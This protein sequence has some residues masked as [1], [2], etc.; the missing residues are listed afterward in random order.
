MG[1]P[2]L[3]QRNGARSL[4]V[5]RELRARARQQAAV[6]ALGQRAL[7]GLG[8]TELLDEAVRVVANTLGVEY[9]KYLEVAPERPHSLF[10]RSGFGWRDGLVGKEYVDRTKGSQ[11]L[12]TLQAAEPVIVEDLR[13]EKR[14][15]SPK[16][17]RDHGVVSG[18]SVLV[19]GP[20]GPYGVLGAHSSRK[21]IFS[22]DDV[23]FLQSVANVLAAAIERRRVE[24]DLSYERECYR[25]LFET[26]LD[27][28]ILTD[29]DGS[30]VDANL[31]AC[32]LTG[33]SREDLLEMTFFD[34][35]PENERDS[36]RDNYRRFTKIGTHQGE[37]GLVRKDGNTVEV[38]YSAA[39]VQRGLFQLVMRDVT[40]RNNLQRMREAFM[41]LA[42]HELR[43]P[44]TTLKGY[45]QILIS[46]SANDPEKARMYH[47]INH[48]SDRLSH[49]VQTLLDLSQIQAG[50]LSL[51]RKRLDLR[52]IVR[53]VA[54]E[55]EDER[56]R[57]IELSLPDEA[58]VVDADPRRVREV[59]FH[60]LD[61]AVKYSPAADKVDVAIECRDGQATVS[62]RDYG[63]GIPPLKQDQLFQ[64]FFQ[65]APMTNPTTGMGLGLHISRVIVHGHGG[66]IWF[67]SE[68]GVG[69]TFSFSL[70]LAKSQSWSGSSDSPR[71][72]LL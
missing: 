37:Y 19:P 27:A 9:C 52:S 35:S 32:K 59:V 16:L 65:V 28:I 50:E 47:A 23:N 36:A 49:L 67:V 18:M 63:A 62:I 26:A 7:S 22:R 57:T 68:P 45:T 58:V 15:K 48:Q 71:R 60:L 70:P 53:G 44:L 54:T 72:S 69:S 11:A 31:Q 29:R 39:T 6:A 51:I 33:Y 14:F 2:E 8:L 21:I 30:F 25:A 4:S 55:I 34:L 5:I 12:Y 40:E 1:R 42:A 17:L 3:I 64:A 43:T 10:L 66:H 13:T 56:Q 46:R 24:E 38:E 41:N 61:N 20:I